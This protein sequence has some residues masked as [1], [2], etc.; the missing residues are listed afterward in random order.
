MA[1]K[2][3]GAAKKT[4]GSTITTIC[5]EFTSNIQ[6][7]GRISAAAAE[8]TAIQKLAQAE[9][10]IK[11]LLT[12]YPQPVAIG[13]P[14]EEAG[15]AGA[16]GATE[17]TGATEGTGTTG[18]AGAAGAASTAETAKHAEVRSDLERLLRTLG[19]PPR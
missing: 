6:A 10:L 19:P 3:Q 12:K 17:A 13:R 15:A 4:S 7:A 8:A 16:A 11:D 18:A 5:L 2:V 9:N 1:E 14:I